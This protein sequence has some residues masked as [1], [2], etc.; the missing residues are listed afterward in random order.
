M[1]PSFRLTVDGQDV[2][3]HGSLEEAKQTA[4]IWTAERRELE[5][6]STELNAAPRAA[7]VPPQRWYY[8]YDSREW[9]QK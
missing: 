6:T 5:I 2:S 1:Q 9:V 7:A 4:Q 3:I 8:D